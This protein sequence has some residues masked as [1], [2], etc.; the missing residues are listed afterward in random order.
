MVLGLYNSILR[1]TVSLSKCATAYCNVRLKDTA[2]IFKRGP[3][4]VAKSLL[5][6]ARAWSGG[7]AGVGGGGSGC[8]S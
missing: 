2:L 1:I 4:G 6:R 5:R 3:T 7:G 8:P